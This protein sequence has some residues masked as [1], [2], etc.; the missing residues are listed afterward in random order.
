MTWFLL[1]L[2][3]LLYALGLLLMHRRKLRLGTYI[4]GAFGLAFLIVQ[5][6]VMQNWHITLQTIEAHHVQSILSIV[7]IDIQ[8]VNTQT[9]LVPDSTGWS[10]L[11]IGAECSSLLEL[12]VFSGLMAFY[13]QLPLRRRWV[14]FGLGIAGIY[15]LNLARIILIVLMVV[16][17]G[18]PIVPFAHIFVARIFYFAG[19]VILYWVF[20]TQ[21]MLALIRQS[22]QRHNAQIAEQDALY[23]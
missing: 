17:W 11:N 7:Q 22:M 15:L 1:A 2:L 8:I 21:P 4:F 5:F 19:I 6:S 12:A 18:K 10:G 13:P 23:V 9:L 20:L 16:V 3:T 14:S